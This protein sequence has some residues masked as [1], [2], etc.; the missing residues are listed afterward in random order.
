LWLSTNYR[1]IIRVWRRIRLIPFNARFAQ[2]DRDVELRGKLQS[3]LPGILAWAVGGA[4]AYFG[5]GLGKSA[6]VDG[7]TAVYRSDMDTLSLFLSQTCTLKSGEF[8]AAFWPPRL[9]A[10]DVQPTAR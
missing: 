2:E 8:S 7:A 4:Q 1:P 9:A 5:E 6:A 10:D 3:E